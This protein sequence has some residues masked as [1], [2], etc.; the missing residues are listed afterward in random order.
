MAKYIDKCETSYFLYSTY[1]TFTVIKGAVSK[2][3]NNLSLGKLLY[4]V[5]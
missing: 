1:F 4:G 3:N 2:R 5:I